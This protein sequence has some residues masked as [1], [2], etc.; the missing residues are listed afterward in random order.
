MKRALRMIVPVF[1]LA[2]VA[3]SSAAPAA[4]TA[5]ARKANYDLASRWTSQKVGKLVFDT[6]VQAHWLE[7]GD[8]F[9]YMFETGKGRSFF[10]VDPFLKARKPL[11]DNAKMAALLT[12]TTLVPYDAQHLPIKT[13][14]FIKKDT[15]I[16]FEIEYPKDNEVL[17]GGILKKVGDIGKELEDKEKEKEKEQDKEK[18]D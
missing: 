15:A 12:R 18:K 9:W 6:A 16:R 5:V 11:F 17:A 2:L 14:K 7:T 1:V 13:I 3:G 4:E 8:R 10:I